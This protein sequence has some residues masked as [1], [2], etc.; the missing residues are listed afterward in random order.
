MINRRNF[1]MLAAG[2]VLGVGGVGPRAQADGKTFRIAL[3]KGAGNLIFLKERGILERKL[4]PLGC[5]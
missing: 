3:Q 4:A 1:Q 5:R 2:L